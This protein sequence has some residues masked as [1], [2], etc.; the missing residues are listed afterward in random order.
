MFKNM[1][2]Y[3]DFR[4]YLRFAG[5]FFLFY[6]SYTFVIAAAAPTGTYYPFVDKFLNFPLVVRYCVLHTGQLLL[7]LFGYATSI[8]GG[9]IISRDGYSML[10]MAWPCYGLGVKSFWIAFVCAH[11]MVPKEKIYWSVAGVLVIFVLNCIRVMVMM[12]A[13]VEKWAI[14]EYLGINAHDLFNYLCYAAL[15]GLILFFYS[16]NKQPKYPLPVAQL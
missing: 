8:E 1:L 12:I 16:K 15:L 3:F 13:M 6:L 2:R 7:T 4:Y 5:L 10:E 11:Q 14:A 9:R